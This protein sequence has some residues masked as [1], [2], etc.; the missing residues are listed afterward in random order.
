[1]LVTVAACIGVVL[2]PQQQLCD[3]NVPKAA[4]SMQR[5]ITLW[6]AAAAAEIV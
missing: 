6:T 4:S 2:M 3:L 1:M 5:V